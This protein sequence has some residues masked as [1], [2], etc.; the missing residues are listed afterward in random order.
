[1]M[2]STS[3]TKTFVSC[4]Y[5][6]SLGITSLTPLFRYVAAS[7]WLAI[8]MTGPYRAYLG[9]ADEPGKDRAFGL[10]TLFAL[11]WI[12]MAYIQICWID[13]LKRGSMNKML[14]FGSMF[15]TVS[16]VFRAIKEAMNGHY[17]EHRVLMV[18]AFL[19]SL[20]GAG[21]IR[22]VA[23]IQMVLGCGPIYCQSV[24]GKVGGHCDWTYTWRMT[25]IMALRIA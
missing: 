20:D 10:H 15:Y 21:T 9:V 11:L 4:L 23:N 8:T 2:L 6:Y 24:Y 16:T 19:S 18:R 17:T 14:L 12:T 3:H 5:W 25:W 1:M 22:T 7:E 13:H